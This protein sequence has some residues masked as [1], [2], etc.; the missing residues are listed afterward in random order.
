MLVEELPPGGL[1]EAIALAEAKG[2]LAVDLKRQ[3]D[4]KSYDESMSYL[5]KIKHLNNDGALNQ[6]EQKSSWSPSWNQ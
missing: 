2:P 3:M 1:L 5:N 4:L 6:D